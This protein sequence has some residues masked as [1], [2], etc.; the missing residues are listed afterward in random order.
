MDN[1]I[2][3]TTTYSKSHINY[4]KNEGKYK[5]K[6]RIMSKKFGVET[7]KFI[8]CKT[9]IELLEKLKNEYPL[10]LLIDNMINYEMKYKRCSQ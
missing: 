9:N 1:E 8:G 7:S 10:E 5:S 6:I 3:K 4:Y 2:K